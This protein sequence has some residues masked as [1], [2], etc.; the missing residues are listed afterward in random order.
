[1]NNSFKDNVL[2]LLLKI[3]E[4][5]VTTYGI[6][7]EK[8]GLKSSARQIGYIL[9]SLK[10]DMSYP[11]HR[12]VNRLGILSGKSHFPDADYMQNMLENE[13]IKIEDDKVVN[14]KQHIWIPD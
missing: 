7:A 1:L 8:C 4:G 5:K 14:L 11:C 9:N 10:N 13:G 2:E 6:I 12:V 3:P